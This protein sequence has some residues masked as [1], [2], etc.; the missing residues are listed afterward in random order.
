M[1]LSDPIQNNG[2]SFG[3]KHVLSSPIAS[4]VVSVVVSVVDSSV[5]LFVVVSSYN[6]RNMR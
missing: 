3:V 4:V 5:V 1:H 2:R 6:I